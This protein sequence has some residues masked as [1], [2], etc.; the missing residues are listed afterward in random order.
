VVSPAVAARPKSRAKYA[1][2]PARS[3]SP[4]TTPKGVAALTLN[5]AVVPEGK[6]SSVLRT[7]RSLLSAAA[8]L[9]LATVAHAVPFTWDPINSETWAGG[10]G[11]GGGS[12]G[13][14]FPFF[15]SFGIGGGATGASCGGLST[16]N[17]SGVR[18]GVGEFRTYWYGNGA[19][20]QAFA[21]GRLIFTPTVP[22][23]SYS[24][25]G[26]MIAIDGGVATRLATAAVE[27]HPDYPHP[28]SLYTNN[29]SGSGT[30]ALWSP[31]TPQLGSQTGNLVQGQQYVMRWDFRLNLTG[32]TDPTALYEIKMKA[33]PYFQFRL[34]QRPCPGDLT[35][36]GYVDDTDF[37]AFAAAYSIL[38]CADPAMPPGCPSDLNGDGFVDD[39]DFVIFAASYEN[40]ICP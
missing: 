3:R 39:A 2:S 27:L 12:S 7:N 36:D 34:Y 8:T 18:F 17:A 31:S 16:F 29:V 19:S 25:E 9:T 33:G 32:Q 26:F 24:F 14:T 37:V 6:E 15:Y 30:F 21:Y 4:P 35:G 38:D 40:L 11:A 5:A 13:G 22:N 10:S 20:S 1:P 28:P 23:L